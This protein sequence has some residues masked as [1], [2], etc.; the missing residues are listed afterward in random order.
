MRRILREVRA[1]GFVRELIADSEAGYPRLKA[2][3]AQAAL[4]PIERVAA[5]LKALSGQRG[6]G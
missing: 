3:R 4:H 6:D 2:S 5:E 1:G